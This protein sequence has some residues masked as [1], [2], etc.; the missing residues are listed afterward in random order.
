MM[1]IAVDASFISDF[2]QDQL[3]AHGRQGLF[4]V[5]V[6]FLGSFGFIRM[7][8]RLIRSPRVPWW[9]GSV[10]SEGGLHVHHLVFGIWTMV[11]AGALAIGL[12]TQSPFFEI[13][14]GFF[15]I[16]V[17][18]TI[19]E[20]ALWVHLEDVYWLKEG[21]SSIDAF[22]LATL[23]MGLILIGTDPFEVDDTTS[24]D[25]VIS[26]VLI[27]VVMLCVAICFLK[28]RVVH[29]TI[30]FFLFP[31]AVYGACRI[32]KPGSPFARRRYAGKPMQIAKAQARF[33]STR[34][35]ARFKEFV[36]TALGGSTGEDYERKLAARGRKE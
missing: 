28:E 1:P 13:A 36:R 17:G 34:R 23:V 18:L 33:A 8:T 20:F 22:V 7:S 29:G 11:L 21:R 15:G 3:V 25:L 14:C 16:G 30:G 2:W 4:L 24:A 31:L 12:H 27:V 19:D 32:G 6:G 35:T 9:P 10:V 26:I 5:L